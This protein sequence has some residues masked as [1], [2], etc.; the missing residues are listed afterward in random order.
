VGS[1]EK[2]EGEREGSRERDKGDEIKREGRM[3][4]GE[5]RREGGEALTCS[6]RYLIAISWL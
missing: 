4:M 3:E 5:G 2:G 1:R 6:C